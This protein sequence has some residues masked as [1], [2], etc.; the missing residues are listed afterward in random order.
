MT[1]TGRPPGDRSAVCFHG[2][3]LSAEVGM[4]A[5]THAPVVNAIGDGP[6]AAVNVWHEYEGG[7]NL[8][9]IFCKQVWVPTSVSPEQYDDAYRRGVV[10]AL[11]ENLVELERSVVCGRVSEGS[12]CERTMDG[13]LARAKRLTPCEQIDPDAIGMASRLVFRAGLQPNLA[14]CS[15][16]DWT[17][18]LNEMAAYDSEFGEVAIVASDWMPVGEAIVLNREHVGIVPLIT[19]NFFAMKCD[20]PPPDG[21][22]VGEYTLEIRE[23]GGMVH[24]AA[25]STHKEHA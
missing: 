14:I 10:D 5:F 8:L 6:K 9:Q 11:T 19:R 24:L 13:L 7:R 18:R 15:R 17:G 2:E 1:F 22:V 25:T 20:N 21:G 16:P 23:P 3:D 4:L 12:D